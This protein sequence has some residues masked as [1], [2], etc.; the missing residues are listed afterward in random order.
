[1][2]VLL[3]L[4]LCI[5]AS[6]CSQDKTEN[7]Q[8]AVKLLFER[9]ETCIHF[10]GELNGDRSDRDKEVIAEMDKL[11]CADIDKELLN[12]KENTKITPNY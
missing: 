8:N 10:S 3:L 11:K 1:M 5:F 7:N 2:K 9:A 6:A 4:L 12:A